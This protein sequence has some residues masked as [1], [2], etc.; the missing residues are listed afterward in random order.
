MKA[1]KA[2]ISRKGAKS[3][4]KTKIEGFPSA[5]G[6]CKSFQF[7]SLNKSEIE[8]GVPQFFASFAA[9]RENNLFSSFSQ[10]CIF[11]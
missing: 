5:A 7:L 11:A 4:K 3:A 1:R 10:V 9:L 6:R 2:F 8:T